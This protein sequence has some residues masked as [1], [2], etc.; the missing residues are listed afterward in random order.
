MYPERM[1][2]STEESQDPSRRHFLK[3]LAG[4]FAA[5]T[6][7]GLLVHEISKPTPAQ[8]LASKLWDEYQ[9]D[10]KKFNEAHP[11][12]VRDYL[13]ASQDGV[14]FRLDPSAVVKDNIVGHRKPG[15]SVGTGILLPNQNPNDQD[16]PWLTQREVNRMI[17]FSEKFIKEKP[18]GFAKP[19]SAGMTKNMLG[20]K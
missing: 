7:I 20:P 18:P 14:N 1:S 16:G 12:L 15:E 2:E 10:P 8:E 13:V 6:G 3:M 4:G 9:R 17:F 19:A 11:G 5:L